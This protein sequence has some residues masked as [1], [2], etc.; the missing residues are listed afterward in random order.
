MHGP[1]FPV[2]LNKLLQKLF[3]VNWKCFNMD[4]GL[5]GVKIY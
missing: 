1:G 2:S 5:D 3:V 4:R